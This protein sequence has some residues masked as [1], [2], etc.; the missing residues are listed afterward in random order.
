V[1]VREGLRGGGL[2]ARLVRELVARARLQAVD[3][4]ED[5]RRTRTLRAD[6][7]EPLA[8]RFPEAWFALDPDRTA[9]RGYYASACFRHLRGRS[10]RPGEPARQP[11]ARRRPA[12]TR[13]GPRPI[14]PPATAAP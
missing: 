9:G 2:G 10:V 3:S 11:V 12:G 1:S 5:G 14:R 8:G 4:M 13:R 6:V 7:L